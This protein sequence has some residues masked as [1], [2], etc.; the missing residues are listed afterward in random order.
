[1]QPSGVLWTSYFG[2]L[3]IGAWESETYIAAA[4]Q[5]GEAIRLDIQRKDEK[6]GIS[7]DELQRIKNE[8]GFEDKDAVEF[9]P[10]QK[11][12]INTANYRHLYIY[13]TPLPLVRRKG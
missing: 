6:D 1:M 11:D 8:C 7:W 4:F 3:S 5:D 2:E 12:V 9:Y 13:G 10:R